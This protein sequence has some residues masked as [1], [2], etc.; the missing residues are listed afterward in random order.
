MIPEGALSYTFW[1]WRRSSVDRNVYEDRHGAFHAALA[2]N[3]T[4]GFLSSNSVRL[5][6]APWA[7]GGGE[8]YQDRYLVDGWATLERLEAAAIS[9][10]RQ[11]P[12]AAIAASAGGGAGGVYGVRSG[13]PVPAPRNSYWFSKPDGMSYAQLDEA[14]SPFVR[15]STVLWIRRMVLG[16][17][18]EFCLESIS[19]VELPG[20]F[21]A[22][23]VLLEPIWPLRAP[24]EARV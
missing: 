1:H 5:T 19:P 22:L 15:D 21:S 11:E 8:A 20:R 23:T 9:G 6:R 12:H 14:L 17:T 13:T 7:N 2:S 4:Q 16:P 10:A 18:P 24:L 3:P